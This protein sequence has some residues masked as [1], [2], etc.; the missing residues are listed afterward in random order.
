MHDLPRLY[1]Q[2]QCDL[3]DDFLPFLE[4]YVVDREYGGFLCAVRPNGE[5]VSEEKRTW[6]QGRGVWVFAYLFNNITREQKYLDVAAAAIEL[7]KRSKPDDPDQL[8][9]K[10]LNRDGTP[11]GEADTEVYGDMFVAEGLAEFAKASGDGTLWNEARDLVFR[12]VSHYDRADYHPP[13]GETYLGPGARPFPGA[14]IGGVWMVLIRTLSQ[15]IGWRPDAALEALLNRSIAAFLDHHYNPRFRLF[16]ELICH[17]LSRPGNEYERLVYAGHAIE[18]LWMIL[19]EARR[20]ADIPLFDTAAAHFRRHCEVARDRVYGG[21]F[22]NLTDVDRNIW[23]LDKTLFPH[24]EALIG[25]LLMIE[26]TGDPWALEFYTDLETY[27][28]ARFPM[29]S[30]NSPLWQLTGDRQVTPT[31]DMVRAENYHHPRFLMLNLQTIG[32]MIERK[33][34]PR[35]AA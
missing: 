10:L 2:Y 7:L 8:R 21:L 29:R 13:I 30:L 15:M 22:R 11:A 19:C 1:A 26:E 14:R 33:G 32:R 4:R 28:R 6:Y 16:N 24:Q 34:K 35:R 5:R 20:R 23:T 3:F 27:V 12:C 31:P 17:D 9:P 25:S 18:T